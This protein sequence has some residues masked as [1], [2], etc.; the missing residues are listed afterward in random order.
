MLHPRLRLVIE[1]D[2]VSNDRKRHQSA[3]R[4]PI[5]SH[6]QVLRHFN[7][8]EERVTHAQ[9]IPAL[10]NLSWLGDTAN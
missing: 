1:L 4:K 10:C 7:P 3:K 8:D 5:T 6:P 9:E 2:R